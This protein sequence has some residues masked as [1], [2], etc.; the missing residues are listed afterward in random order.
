M[1]QSEKL[2]LLKKLAICKDDDKKIQVIKEVVDPDMVLY[3]YRPFGYDEEKRHKEVLSLKNLTPWSSRF[4]KLDDQLEGFN[5]NSGLNDLQNA[6]SYLNRQNNSIAKLEQSLKS[7]KSKND[8]QRLFDMFNTS[9]NTLRNMRFNKISH[10]SIEVGERDFRKNFSMVCFTENSPFNKNNLWQE[11]TETGGFCIEYSLFDIL[12]AGYIITPIYYMDDRSL[13]TIKQIFGDESYVFLTKTKK[14][15][16]KFTKKSADWEHQNEWR[17]VS[18]NK[19][20]KVGGCLKKEI[21][22]KRVIAM[23]IPNKGDIEEIV[24]ELNRIKGLNIMYQLL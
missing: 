19:K 22:P 15:K 6:Q 17:I 9:K 23:N 14:G 13:S 12:D 20:C 24:K 5:S 3:R 2:E 18:N 11:Y 8:R 10:K 21:I 7:A 1:T 16:N 4:D